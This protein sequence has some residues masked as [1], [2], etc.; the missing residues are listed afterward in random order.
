METSPAIFSEQTANGV[1]CSRMDEAARASEQIIGGSHGRLAMIAA[2]MPIR[3][4][5][6]T[7]GVY[8]ALLLSVAPVIA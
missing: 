5:V 6:V 1:S 8:Y 4:K 3:V 7:N 2:M